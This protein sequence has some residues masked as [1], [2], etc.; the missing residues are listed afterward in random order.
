MSN[1]LRNKLIKMTF[2][3]KESRTD[4]SVIEFCLSA[5]GKI[6]LYGEH[7]VV[8]GRTGVAAS[9]NLRT[10]V[11]F[12]ETSSEKITIKISQIDLMQSFDFSK[13]KDIIRKPI[14]LIDE[15][16]KFSLAD[17]KRID[18]SEFLK[19]I[20]EDIHQLGIRAATSEQSS[21]LKGMVYLMRGILGSVDIEKRSFNIDMYSY[22]RIGAGTGSSASFA[23]CLAAAFF[24]YLRLKQRGD[25][26]SCGMNVARPDIEPFVFQ[27]NDSSVFSFSDQEKEIINA[28]AYAVERI[29]HGKPSG[30]DNTVCTYGSV[31]EMNRNIQPGEEP[32]FKILCNTPQLH[33]LLV[34]TGVARTTSVLVEK[35]VSLKTCN[36]KIIEHILDA[37]NEIAN[38]ASDTLQEL[39]ELE[40][41]EVSEDLKKPLFKTLE[42][43]IDLN[44][45][46]LRTLGVSHPLLEKI[47]DVS[48]QY[49][50]HSKLTGAGGGGYAYTLVPPD[51]SSDQLAAYWQDIQNEGCSVSDI[52]IG[53]PGLVIEQCLHTVKKEN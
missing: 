13:V 2:K 46:L 5:P 44:H 42:Q 50:L 35:V 34:N 51:F 23:I 32:V 41:E 43:L 40:K 19:E 18:H 17:P 27:I 38:K 49:G 8:Y 47:C 16:K 48:A 20:Q 12:H 14:P 31:V 10:Y 11:N 6:I 25:S 15:T 30:L 33:I 45:G 1:Y 26:T 4:N 22:L 36:P 9:I 24:H 3:E 29:M 39:G 28:W 21:A 52:I 37:M 53:G 7:S